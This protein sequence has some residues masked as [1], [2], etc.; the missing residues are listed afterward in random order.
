[1]AATLFRVL[2]VVHQHLAGSFISPAMLDVGAAVNIP[3]IAA[4]VL[5]ALLLGALGAA[6]YY[7]FGGVNSDGG[8]SARG[9]ASEMANLA[10]HYKAHVEQVVSA[11]SL[12]VLLVVVIIPFAYQFLGVHGMDDGGTFGKNP[13]VYSGGLPGAAV[14][15]DGPVRLAV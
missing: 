6:A 11:H 3:A 15:L 7:R 8:P 2:T 14:R 5:F 1:M 4:A 12:R 10:V 9:D 13:A